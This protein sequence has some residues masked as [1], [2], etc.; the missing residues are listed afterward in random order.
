M[1]EKWTCPTQKGPWTPLILHSLHTC[2]K[3]LTLTNPVELNHFLHWCSFKDTTKAPS[4]RTRLRVTGQTW[5]DWKTGDRRQ[6]DGAPGS[7]RLL[8]LLAQEP[9]LAVGEHQVPGAPGGLLFVRVAAR[10]PGTRRTPQVWKKRQK[11]RRSDV[12][13]SQQAPWE[14]QGTTSTFPSALTSARGDEC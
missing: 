9:H 4:H 8:L 2:S 3:K 6:K 14:F 7:H 13:E 5:L 1:G 11:K 12:K 10:H